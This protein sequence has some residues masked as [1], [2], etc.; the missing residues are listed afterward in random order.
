MKAVIRA[1]EL[2]AVAGLVLLLLL[3]TTGFGL[4]A[5]YVP[6]SAEAFASVLDLRQSG[7]LGRFLRSL[8]ERASSG[9]VVAGFV[10]LLAA[11]L[12]GRLAE[13]RK[14]FWLA[15][16]AYGLVLAACFTGF[17]LPMDQNAY[18]GSLVR[19]G[20]VETA[21]MVGPT[22]ASVLRGGDGLN[23]TTLPR[24]Y[25]L[26]V[27]LLPFLLALL[28][29]LLAFEA[30]SVLADEARRRR[31]LR[32]ALAAL[33][34]AFAVAAVWPAPLEPAANP[35]DTSYV[36]RPEW[37][38]TWLF[39]LGKYVEGHEW[40]RSLLLPV[41]GGSLLLLLPFLSPASLQRRAAWAAGAVL[42]I[43]GLTGVSRYEDRLLPPKPT[44]EQ[45]LGDRAAF[46]F[47]T[48][49]RDCHGAS[50][51][52][53]GEQAKSSAL[54]VPDFNSAEFWKGTTREE[55]EQA[56]REGR[57]EDMPS[58]RRKLRDDEIAALVRRI[59]E[60]FRPRPAGVR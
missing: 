3:L 22:A 44:Y 33:V 29:L 1:R 30:R 39:E 50:G 42:A 27:S 49:C 2:A 38:F 48:V 47:A 37:Y 19:L 43:A 53:D 18:W 56:V 54:D 51:H 35:A 24:F 59:E 8:H 16:G 10:Y 5:S 21:P 9:L 15:L 46:V 31:A 34:L 28:L 11:F 60:R 52:G 26:H 32:E 25:A 45:A 23:A 57:G 7:A 40:I 17:L 14:A 4:M 58:F 41:A 12:E 6:S 36:P 55:M 20:I 13:E